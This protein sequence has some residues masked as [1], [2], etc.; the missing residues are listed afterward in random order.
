M[1]AP[2]VFAFL[3]LFGCGSPVQRQ[4]IT[5]PATAMTAPATKE[6]FEDWPAYGRTANANHF[7]PLSEI[8][9]K[10]AAKLGLAWF[11]NV[12]NFGSLGTPLVLNGVLYY[13]TG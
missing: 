2:V 8:N 10:N 3:S 4:V 11:V 6:D 1:R 13:P 5:Q 12:P 9:D 7:S